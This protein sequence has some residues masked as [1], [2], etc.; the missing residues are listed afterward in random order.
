MQPI[1]QKGR[2]N[3]SKFIRFHK[4]LKTSK[5]RSKHF[6]QY[7]IDRN[8]ESTFLRIENNTYIKYF[9]LFILLLTQCLCYYMIHW[10][11]GYWILFLVWEVLNSSPHKGVGRILKHHPKMSS[12]RQ[13]I[14]SFLKIEW[15]T[16][17][18]QGGNETKV[19]VKCSKYFD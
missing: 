18:T 5:W 16:V 11:P 13:V 1:C 19:L 8:G 4:Y 9:T 12:K 3:L 10:N 15:S 14:F 6:F 2:E 17:S 7:Q